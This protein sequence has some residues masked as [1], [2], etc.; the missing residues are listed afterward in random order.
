MNEDAKDSEYKHLKS[1]LGACGYKSLTFEKALKKS[2]PKTVVI[3]SNRTQGSESRRYN[4]TIQNVL[5]LT[6][7]IRIISREVSTSCLVNHKTR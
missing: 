1:A 4:T 7:D 5:K 2:K 6:E 3:N